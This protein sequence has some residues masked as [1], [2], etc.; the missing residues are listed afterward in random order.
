PGKPASSFTRAPT[1]RH[2]GGLAR[3][4][5][6]MSMMAG[7]ASFTLS[8]HAQPESA[9]K[10]SPKGEAPPSAVGEA[11]GEQRQRFRPPL[12]PLPEL[13]PRQ[14]PEPSADDRAL[15]DGLLNRLTSPSDTE[16]VS[17]AADL[18]EVSESLVPAIYERINR[19]T[20][21]EE[22]T[23]ELQSR[24]NLVCRLLLE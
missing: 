15:L 11:D 22:H 10:D 20:R 23:S 16:R 1:L 13:P 6:A 5:L 17:A 8:A 19:E 3:A 24:E 7:I 18:S 2:R 12:E 9:S 14:F 4:L 21:S